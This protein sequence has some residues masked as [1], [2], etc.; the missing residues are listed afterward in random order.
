MILTNRLESFAKENKL[1]DD[2][3]IGF[4]KGSRTVDH[5]FIL[6]S[7]IEKYVKNLTRHCIHVCFVDF[8]KAYDSVWRQARLYKLSRMDINGMSSNSSNTILNFLM[9]Y[10]TNSYYS[11]NYVSTNF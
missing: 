9:P 10:V 1:I 5:M 8:R 7:L 2:K 11:R 6:A 4:K 3:Q